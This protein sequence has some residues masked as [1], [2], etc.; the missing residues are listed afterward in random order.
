MED[1]VRLLDGLY[2]QFLA[3][4]LTPSLWQT[5]TAVMRTWMTARDDES[6]DADEGGEQ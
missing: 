1:A 2:R 6:D 4:R 3:L 5:E